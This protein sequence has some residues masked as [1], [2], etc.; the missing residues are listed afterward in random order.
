MLSVGEQLR[1]DLGDPTTSSWE[2][3][4]VV[5][6]RV[7]AHCVAVGTVCGEPRAGCA[8]SGCLSRSGALPKDL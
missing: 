5:Q 4:M 8:L 6:V 2:N 3:K 7:R 1:R